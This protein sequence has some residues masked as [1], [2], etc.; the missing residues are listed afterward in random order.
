MRMNRD[1]TGTARA[2]LSTPLIAIV[3]ACG[4][5]GDTGPPPPPDVGV[6]QP[7][8]REVTV[9]SEHL[10]TTEAFESVEVRARV[11]GELEQITF[12]PST[13]VSENDVLFVI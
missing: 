6:S 7:I 10:G 5:G 8:R 1:G 3:A 4:G 2:V 9:F 12:E 11:T 13:T